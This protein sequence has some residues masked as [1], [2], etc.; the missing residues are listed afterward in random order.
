MHVKSVYSYL[1]IFSYDINFDSTLQIN[2]IKRLKCNVGGSYKKLIGLVVGVKTG[3][4]DRNRWHL[5]GND[6]RSTG[7]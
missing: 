4:N 5:F 3:G 2:K 6:A 7:N 1:K